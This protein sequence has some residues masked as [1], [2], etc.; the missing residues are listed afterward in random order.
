M[1]DIT[2][3]FFRDIPMD[4]AGIQKLGITKI[5]GFLLFLLK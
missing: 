4:G 3:C 5:I 1:D 2:P